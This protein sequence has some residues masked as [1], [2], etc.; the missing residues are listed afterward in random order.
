M[1]GVTLM[2]VTLEENGKKV[3]QLLTENFTGVWSME[4]TI[5]PWNL[6]INYTGNLYSPMRLP[7]LGQ[8]DDRSEYSPWFSIQNIQL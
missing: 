3:R 6:K 2:D 4:Y 8:L 7:L 5:L 1:G